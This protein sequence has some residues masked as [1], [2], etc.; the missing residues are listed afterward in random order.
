MIVFAP[1]LPLFHFFF[2]ER[3][4][5]IGL[6]TAAASQGSCLRVRLRRVSR[7]SLKLSLVQAGGW[8]APLH[9]Y[10]AERRHTLVGFGSCGRQLGRVEL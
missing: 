8:G 5:L 2:T 3:K 1:S 6:D 7:D 9:R 10:P 4:S